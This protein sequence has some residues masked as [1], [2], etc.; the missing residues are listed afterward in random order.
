MTA[1]RMPRRFGA[2]LGTAGLV[3]LTSVAGTPG[4]AHAAA[5]AADTGVTVVISGTEGRE[6]HCAPGSSMTA[7]AA[8]QAVAEVVQVQKFPGVVC[9]IDG[10]PDDQS[11]VQMPPA[12]A[13]WSFYYSED[14]GDWVYS[15]VGAPGVELSAGDAVAWVYSGHEPG[16][17]PAASTEPT[18]ASTQPTSAGTATADDSEKDDSAKDDD[19]RLGVTLGGAAV[20]GLGIAAFVVA[21]KRNDDIG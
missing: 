19:S 4:P 9:Q 5:C 15:T 3:A 8:T 11:C 7:L 10:M 21:R 1:Q 6:V 17:V 18:S 13:Y 16:E 12:D 2:V 14:G 20:A